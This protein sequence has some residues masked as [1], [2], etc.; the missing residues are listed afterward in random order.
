MN[1]KGKGVIVAVWSAN[2]MPIDKDGNR[3]DI[4]MDPNATVSRMNLGRLYEHYISGAARDVTKRV[5]NIIGNI[6]V[7]AASDAEIETAYNMVVD[8]Y[9]VVSSRMEKWFR[10]TG[11]VDKRKHIESIIKDGIYLYIPPENEKEPR[12]IVEALETQF[13]QTYGPV[14][15][16]GNSGNLVTTKFPVRIAPMYIMLLEKTADDWSAV[17]SGILQHFGVLAPIPKSL[18]YTKPSR[19]Q[20]VRAMGETETRISVSYVGPKV[21]AD[22]MDRNNSVKTHENIVESILAA[23]QPTNI[24][25]AVDR[26]KNPMGEA[27]PLQI[28]KHIAF[29]CGWQFTYKHS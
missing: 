19:N 4:I 28:V 11:N 6:P 8:F 29:C 27:R 14:Q 20:A 15:Y 25:T 13:P 9:S 12:R 3:A 24:N 22:I 7:I 1:N 5:K 18:R 16:I 10:N 21:T 26:I 23:K 2:R 17:S